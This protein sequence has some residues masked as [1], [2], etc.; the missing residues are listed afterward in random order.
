MK[1]YWS[2]AKSGFDSEKNFPQE[3]KTPPVSGRDTV[4]KGREDAVQVFSDENIVETLNIVRREKLGK[5]HFT[6]EVAYIQYTQNK[7]AIIQQ[8]ATRGC[9]AAAA[10]MLIKDK[11][12]EIDFKDLENCNLGD[13]ES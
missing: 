8:Q 9:S 6:E 11:E 2:R 13:D 4:G 10:A 12:G 5:H 7:K 1:L 3:R